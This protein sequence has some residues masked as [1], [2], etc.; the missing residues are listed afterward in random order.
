MGYHMRWCSFVSGHGLMQL[1]SMSKISKACRS[2]WNTK[3]YF[4]R[5]YFRLFSVDH[6][7]VT[8]CALL[9]LICIIHSIGGAHSA[10]AQVTTEEWLAQDN[11]T[12]NWG[13][14]RDRLNQA[15]IDPE[16]NFTTDL[17]ANPI[18]GMRQNGAYAGLWYGSTTFDLEKLAGLK[19]LEFYVGA[20]WAQG[21]DLSGD[22]VGNFFGVA[23]VFNGRVLRLAD[24]YLQQSLFEDRLT[25]SIGRLVAGNAFAAADAYGNYVN[26]AVNGNPT[27]ILA[28]V[29]SFTTSPFSQ[30]GAQVTV[31]PTQEFYVSAGI[32]NADADVQ[33]DAYHGLDFT[34]NPQDGV[35]G[36]VEVGYK[37]N[38]PA[39]F[40]GMPGQYSFGAY[41]D[42]TD[43]QFLNNPQRSRSENYGIYAIAQQMVYQESAGSDEGLTLWGTLTVNPD[44][45]INTAPVTVVGGAIYEGLLPQRPK[46]A[47]AIGIAYASFSDDLPGQTYE[48]ALEANHRFQVGEWIY[49]QP[50]VQY[51]INPNGGG[52]PDALVAGAEISIDF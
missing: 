1:S 2:R 52:I 4:D 30:W 19:G 16:L 25:A 42:T 50:T 18:G 41:F 3:I 43:Y 48:L 49:F 5:L 22:D 45:E 12:G 9:L 44:S 24:V 39:I 23:Q 35:L 17:L 11:A 46:A 31:A 38:S 33:E 26:A 14:L 21:R 13:D 36:V 32:Y 15:G 8:R 51:I 27:G 29:P 28:N 6:K 10:S 34:F 20:A 37:P 40:N 7:P 47:T